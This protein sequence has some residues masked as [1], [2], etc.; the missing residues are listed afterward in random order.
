M[1]EHE[2]DSLP[3][4]PPICQFIDS[5]HTRLKHASPHVTSICVFDNF[6]MTH[7]WWNCFLSLVQVH[8][9]RIGW[10][11]YDFI[12]KFNQNISRLSRKQTETYQIF[13]ELRKN[14]FL[15]WEYS[16][17]DCLVLLL[18]FGSRGKGIIAIFMLSLPPKACETLVNF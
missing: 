14:T 1:R 16:R 13:D 8:L 17:H 3:P 4:R 10:W 15:N 11:N 18:P 2:S 7:I 6:F 12:K 9:S 5:E